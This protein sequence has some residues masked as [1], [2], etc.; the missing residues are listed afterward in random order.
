MR[1]PSSFHSTDA[2]PV[3]SSAAATS[4]AVDASIGWTGRSS[5][6][7]TAASASTPSVSAR[8]A[9]TRRSP[10]SIAARR[11]TSSGTS[12]ARAIA[13][14]ITPSS[15]PCRSSPRRRRRRKSAS[16]SVA[17]ANS[18]SRIVAPGA[19][20]TR[21]GGVADGVDRVRHVV[22]RERRFG[23]RR[24]VEVADRGPTDADASLRQIADEVARSRRRSLR[25]RGC[26]ATSRAHRPSRGE[27][28]SIATVAAVATRS[29]RSIG[30][31]LIGS[32]VWTIGRAGRARAWPTRPTSR[33]SRPR[34]C[35]SSSSNATPKARSRCTCTPA[36]RATGSAAWRLRSAAR[37][38]LCAPV[39]GEAG[40]VVADLMGRD[41]VALRSVPMKGDSGTYI[42]DRRDGE[43]RVVLEAHPPALGRHVLDQLF[44]VTLAAALEARRVRRRRDAGA[45]A[46]ARR[47]LRAARSPIWSRRACRSSPTSPATCSSPRSP[48]DRTCS[49][50]VTRSSSTTASRAT[51]R[52]A[53]S[54][55]P[56]RSCRSRVRAT[57][58][59]RGPRSPALAADRRRARRDRRAAAARRRS[60]RRGR[61]DDGRVSR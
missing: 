47:D 3:A 40:T 38:V 37:P 22:D 53:S 2:G 8:R 48:V 20:R 16:G 41:K 43:R 56:S 34:S 17:R 15:A 31:I 11:T 52:R 51:T 45:D 49:R 35:S 30:A 9:V 59:C 61:L 7:R 13:S 14:V 6:S 29:A 46:R 1:A 55:A 50:S 28:A 12:A 4:S 24:D 32:S 33:S 25:A 58:W 42:H 36:V 27:N 10:L 39:G 26:R 60:P 5:S 57:S 19:D 44:S 54:H 18:A 23:R 21:A